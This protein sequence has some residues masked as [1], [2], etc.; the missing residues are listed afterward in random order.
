MADESRRRIADVPLFWKLLAPSIALTLVLGVIGTFS[1]VRYLAHEAQANL[2]DDLRRT[3]VGAQVA[4]SDETDYLVETTRVNSHVQGV[5]TALSARRTDDLADLLA[6]AAA[7]RDHADVFVF[8]DGGGTGLVELRRNST[9]LARTSGGK[10]S[11]ASGVATVLRTDVHDVGDET[12]NWYRD[13][14]TQLL[15]VAAP[16]L[17]GGQPIGAA[18]AGT[19]LAQL[20]S[21][22]AHQV[23]SAVALY[24]AGGELLASDARG[25]PARAALPDPKETLRRNSHIG[26]HA[27]TTLFAPI[28]L[29]GGERGAVA[30]SLRRPQT[31]AA[32]VGV[33]VGAVFLA[34]ILIVLA[35]G[36][37]IV[38]GVLGRMRSVLDASRALAAGDL[39]TR[40]PDAGG[41]ELGELST[42]FNVMAEQLEASYRELERRVAERTAELQR[43]YD[44]SVAAAEGRSEFFAAISHELRTPLFVIAGH[45]ELMA[46]PDLQ[47][48]D[49]GWE[50][51]YGQTI[52]QAALDLLAR[53]NE[54]LDL[55]KLET[56]TVVLHRSDVS[57]ADAARAIA[58]ELAPLA[59]QAGLDLRV[60]VPT[61]VPAVRAD[62]VRLAD[63]L[64]NL[65]A[66]AIKYTPGGGR[67]VISAAARSKRVVEIAVRDTGIGI[68]AEAHAHLFEPFYQVP[69]HLQDR[70]RSTGLGLALA[71]RLVEAHGGTLRVDSRVGEG[72]TF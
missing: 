37:V 8:T 11:D 52:H 44:E 38:R 18:I 47:P 49:P 63:I 26:G 21:R 70:Q 30:V 41:D 6:G 58:T 68:P 34:A 12:A 10:W 71:S 45:A 50:Q 65:V 36:A 20:A 51:E 4:L 9:G 42:G 46:H 19:D 43:L 23:G 32:G 16:V 69:G 22:V 64:R 29:R 56:K 7:V 13:N 61:D 35:I 5:Q 31:G 14:G 40:A 1:V 66:N 3:A 27:T 60:E 62:P 48:T 15:L 24:G 54:I 25:A 17:D 28:V 59:R 67:V 53:V 55:A 33:R 57:V 39:S 72:S 2:D